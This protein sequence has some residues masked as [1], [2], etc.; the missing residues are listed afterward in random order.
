MDV[1]IA[2]KYI[3]QH[4]E[5]FGDELYLDTKIRV[6]PTGETK[7]EKIKVLYDLMQAMKNRFKNEYFSR[8]FVW[9]FFEI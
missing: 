1:S 3:S 4:I 9:L 5:L 7:N 2:K 8:C 6:N